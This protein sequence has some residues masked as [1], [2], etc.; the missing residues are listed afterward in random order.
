MSLSWTF[1]CRTRLRGGSMKWPNLRTLIV[2]LFC[3]TFATNFFSNGIIGIVYS[4]DASNTDKEAIVQLVHGR[5]KARL[6]LLNEDIVQVTNERPE[7]ALA[8][9][10]NRPK[11]KAADLAYS[12][13]AAD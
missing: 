2:V 4:N 13:K 9:L 12:L 6:D 10:Q 1:R 3:V 8:M 11:I 5:V 7:D